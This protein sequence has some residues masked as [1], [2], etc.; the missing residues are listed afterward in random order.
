[1]QFHKLF[2]KQ[3]KLFQ[4]LVF[5]FV[6]AFCKCLSYVGW[7]ELALVEKSLCYESSLNRSFMT[8]PA[9]EAHQPQDQGRSVWNCTTDGLCGVLDRKVCVQSDANYEVLCLVSENY[10]TELEMYI[11]DRLL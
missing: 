2:R 5:V 8:Q 4:I 3:Q 7:N 1:M 9:Q 11:K 10:E 6:S